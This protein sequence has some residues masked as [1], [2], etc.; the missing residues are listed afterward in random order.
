MKFLR[1]ERT[2]APAPVAHSISILNSIHNDATH[3]LKAYLSRAFIYNP[4][5]ERKREWGG[6]VR[7]WVDKG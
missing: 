4:E 3:P 1:L 7:V 5:N 2:K 6:A